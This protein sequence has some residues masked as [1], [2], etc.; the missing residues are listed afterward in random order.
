MLRQPVG[1]MTSTITD[2]K[3]AFS[4]K[5]ISGRLPS[6]RLMV[7]ETKR[8]KSMKRER[9]RETERN[10]ESGYLSESPQTNSK[11]NFWC[12]TGKSILRARR[13]SQS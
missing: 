12:G 8:V 1:V 4:S 11:G 3:E 9:G 6:V 13:G 5:K 10:R 2:C 7:K